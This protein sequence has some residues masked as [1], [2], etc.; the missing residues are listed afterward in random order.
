MTILVNFFRFSQ[1]D[2]NANK[3]NNIFVSV[4][5][6]VGHF[7][8]NKKRKNPFV[9]SSGRCNNKVSCIFINFPNYSSLL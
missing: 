3:M 6:T 9:P 5:D 8:N 4:N 2:T 1:F 7:L